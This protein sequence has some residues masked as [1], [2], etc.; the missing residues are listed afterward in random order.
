MKL[1]VINGPNLNFLG[2]REKEI[3][4]EENYDSL[5][6]EINTRKE[7]TEKECIE[8]YNVV[9]EQTKAIQKELDD[10]VND[11]ELK[12]SEISAAILQKQESFNAEIETI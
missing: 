9:A 1:L 4:G 6:N 2:I 10:L 8:K 3:Y 12:R 5:I 7:A 11:N